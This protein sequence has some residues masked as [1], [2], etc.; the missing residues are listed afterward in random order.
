MGVFLLVI[1][2]FLTC[3]VPSVGGAT[4]VVVLLLNAGGIFLISSWLK[5]L[6]SVSFFTRGLD[7]DTLVGTPFIITIVSVLAVI[8]CVSGAFFEIVSVSQTIRVLAEACNFRPSWKTSS[9][10]KITLPFSVKR[11]FIYRI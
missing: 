6:D 8:C 9:S 2:K 11:L 5:P 1:P 4:M 3:I 10:S 7:F